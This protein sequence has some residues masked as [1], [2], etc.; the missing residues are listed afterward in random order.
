MPEQIIQ[1]VAFAVGPLLPTSTL[2]PLNIIHVMNE[3][4][5]SPFFAVL[6]LLCIRVRKLRTPS[7]FGRSF[8]EINSHKDEAIPLDC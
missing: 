1:C 3:P 5:P 6:L 2:H 8:A 4:R 7:K